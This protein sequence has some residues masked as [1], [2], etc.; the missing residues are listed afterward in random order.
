MLFKSVL[1]ALIFSAMTRAQTCHIAIDIGHNKTHHGCTSSRG[2]GEYLFN[3]RV[4]LATYYALK[5]EGINSFFVNASEKEISL[6]QRAEHATA[7]G[8][9]HFIS[10]HHDSVKSRYLKTW[11]FKGENH[12]YSDKFSGYS[13]F[14]SKKNAQFSKSLALASLIGKQLREIGRTPSSHHVINIQGE[15]K[16]FLDSKNGVYQYDNLVVLKKNVIP[17]VLIECGIIL[18][19]TDEPFLWSKGG[20]EEIAFAVTKALMHTCEGTNNE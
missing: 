12:Q 17:A 3:R 13:I 18:N 2:V 14:V 7:H 19:R 10:F 1:Y 8:A 20:V 15:R 9:T 4:A 16:K 6:L 5:A 11:V